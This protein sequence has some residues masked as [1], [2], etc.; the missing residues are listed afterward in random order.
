MAIANVTAAA[1]TTLIKE[2]APDRCGDAL[3]SSSPLMADETVLDKV[4]DVNG[5]YTFTVFPAENTAGGQIA[6]FGQIFV[7]NAD[8]PAKG[9]VL[10]QAFLEIVQLGRSAADLEVTAEGITE[11]F[12]SNVDNRAQAMSR[13]INSAIYGGA[14]SPTSGTTWS[15]S[16]TTGA[17]VATVAF[18]D[19][20]LFRPN[21]PYDF[22]DLSS[23]KTYTVRCVSV[24]YT[25][26]NVA[27]SVVFQNDI[28]SPVTGAPVA[29][30]DTTI[31]TG[32]TFRNRG[33]GS[34]N[35]SFGTTTALSGMIS[36]DAIAGSGSASA[37]HGISAT[38]L[39]GWFGQNR[40]LGAAF[41]QE[42]SLGFSGLMN[43]VA[44]RPYTHLLVP[45]QVAAAIAVS[46]GIQGSV[47]ASGGL[48][49]ALGGAGRFDLG[50]KSA[51]KYAGVD[52]SR[53]G[54]TLHARPVIEDINSPAN[55]IVYHNRDVCKLAVWKKMGPCEEAGDP[56]LLD[57]TTYSY[58]TQIDAR[59][60]LFCKQRAAI[61]VMTGVSAL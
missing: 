24:T 52:G 33:A 16:D 5:E 1:L 58:S 51:D 53:T 44:G 18:A 46:G 31:A 30:T 48:A 56:L 35:G 14:P 39:P 47:L 60:N 43:Q 55:Q 27:A 41:T 59:L 7:G 22:C 13:R 34:A 11:L 4:M 26:S 12:Q 17:G 50:T 40:A 49:P 37:L 9:R 10:P 3:V 20:S 42:A 36:Y 15:L 8:F 23:G 38:Q 19:A 28:P 21:A 54:L 25:T 29:F 45:P 57:R 32:D 6:D 61:G 2:Y